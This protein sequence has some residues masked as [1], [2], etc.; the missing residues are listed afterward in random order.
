MNKK[1]VVMISGKARS[2]KDYIANKLKE[3]LEEKGMT[4]CKFALA[5]ELKRYLCI[6]FDIT[7]DEL[8]DLKN[9]EVKFTSN[10]LTMRQLLQKLGTDVFVKNIDEQ[11]WI[12]KA[13]ERIV[14][15]DCDVSIITDFRY[16]F[17]IDL[18]DQCVFKS[19]K[20][21]FLKL[22][23]INN[24][25]KIKSFEHPSETALDDF[26]EFDIIIDNKDYSYIFNI[27]DFDI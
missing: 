26:D 24:D 20:Y 8:N 9:S 10:G 6:L 27:N 19:S 14:K 15:E 18:I 3:S 2:G 7:L 23:R 21:Y 5:D 17:E 12:K 13:A 1:T 11:F 4:V 25:E 22:I 16:P